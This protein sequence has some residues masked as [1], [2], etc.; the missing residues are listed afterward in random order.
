MC[1]CEL[2]VSEDEPSLMNAVGELNRFLTFVQF[3]YIKTE[4]ICM[5]RGFLFDGFGDIYWCPC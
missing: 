2:N 4:F 1:P 5:S 3:N